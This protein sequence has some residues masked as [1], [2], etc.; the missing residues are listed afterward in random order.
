VLLTVVNNN[1]V[2]LPDAYTYGPRVLRVLPNAV[3]AA[4][5]DRVTIFAYGLGFSDLIDMHVK[6]GGVQVDMKDATMSSY[7]SN[8]YPEQSV[9]VT[10][11]AG[12]PGWADVAM[13]TINSTDTMNR[14]MQY[15]NQEVALAGGPFG[16][17]VYDSAR[18][19]FYLTGS[20]NNI[21]VFNPNTQAFGQPLQSST[22]NAGAVLEEE[23]LTPDSSKLL[24]EGNQFKQPH[25][26]ATDGR[27]VDQR[28][29][30]LA[31]IAQPG[32]DAR[33]NETGSLLYTT[34]IESGQVSVSDTHINGRW[35]L[36]L[37]AQNANAGNGPTHFFIGQ[38]R[39]LA[40]DPVGAKI[41]IGL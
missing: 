41:V 15:L 37:A 35:Q 21:A 20:G 24:V 33:L 32:F 17:T 23:A 38:I 13:T 25:G 12:T 34:G 28:L 8:N 36:I 39:P 2:F 31:Q 6:I 10:I 29:L 7:S 40:T 27:T 19:L 14:A 9:I 4:G 5:G 22:I 1:A 26:A 30:P 11:P 3:S 18:D 16:F